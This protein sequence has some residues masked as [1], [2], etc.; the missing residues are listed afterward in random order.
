MRGGGGAGSE[1]SCSLLFCWKFG[2][3]IPAAEAAALWIVGM[4]AVVSRPCLVPG[5]SRRVGGGPRSLVLACG[6]QRARAGA[7]HPWVATCGARLAWFGART[8]EERAA[9]ASA[10]TT[11]AG[12]GA[13][14][15]EPCQ[16][17]PRPPNA[18][19]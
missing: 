18:A 12:G 7:E 17:T 9:G 10:A 15:P 11:A 5:A 19:T 3:L 2:D 8:R 6:P 1:V 4:R 13:Q 16:R 14:S